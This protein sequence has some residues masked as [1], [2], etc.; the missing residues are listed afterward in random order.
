MLKKTNFLFIISIF[1]CLL[2]FT[3]I[4]SSESNNHEYT[5]NDDKKV[6]LINDDEKKCIDRNLKVSTEKLNEIAAEII[7]KTFE[8]KKIFLITPYVVVEIKIPYLD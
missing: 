6:N 4:L 5:F 3:N 7:K 8:K 1:I 2:K